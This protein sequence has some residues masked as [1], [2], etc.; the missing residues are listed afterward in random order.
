MIAL[1]VA[2]L[3]AQ[4][5]P[6][7]VDALLQD[8]HAGHVKATPQQTDEK[9]PLAIV[10][11]VEFYYTEAPGRLCKNC[12][13]GYRAVVAWDGE[14]AHDLSGAA[15]ITEFLKPRLQGAKEGDAR[16]L[17]AAANA[18]IELRCV[19]AHSGIQIIY[20]DKIALTPVEGGG[21][22]WKSEINVNHAFHTLT[23]AIDKEGAL[24]EIALKD[25]G[26]RC[27]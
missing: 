10:K 3:F 12:G 22:T 6:A 7:K 23:I 11:G 15:E 9:H 2:A 16:A 26:R 27:R 8:K 20:A 5:A 14:K 19:H 24:S 4:A 25:T 1:L 18:L 13:D 21:W 17:V